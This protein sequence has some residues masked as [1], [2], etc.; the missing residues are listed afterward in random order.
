MSPRPIL[1]RG[2]PVIEALAV[3]RIDTPELEPARFDPRRHVPDQAEVLPLIE[4]PHRGRE[5]EYRRSL[6]AEDEQLHV[7]PQRG[8]PPF[9]V[10]TVH[11][12]ATARDRASS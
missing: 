6:V 4:A 9:A 7:A 1:R 11:R 5:D 8:A 10:L 3:D 12:R 2:G